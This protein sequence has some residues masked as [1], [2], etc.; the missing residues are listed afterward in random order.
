MA[1]A[2]SSINFSVETE[3]DK[4]ET[5]HIAQTLEQRGL[6]T[7]LTCALEC[8][9]A[10]GTYNGANACAERVREKLDAAK[11]TSRKKQRTFAFAGVLAVA[12][13]FA[14]L[15]C[16]TQLVI[17]GLE[18]QQ[19]QNELA[20]SYAAAEQLE[21]D[22]EYSAAMRA[23]DDLGSYSDAASRADA[24]RLEHSWDDVRVGDYVWLG[25]YEQDN[26]TTNGTEAVEWRVLAVEDG[27]A[28]IVSLYGLEA[29]RFYTDPTAADANNWEQ[30]ELKAWMET[31]FM[32][33]LFSSDEQQR[34]AS[35]PF[36]LSAD[37]ADEYFSSDTD[38]RCKGTVYLEHKENYKNNSRCYWRLRTAGAQSYYT[39][40]VLPSGQID[41]HARV[42]YTAYAIRPAVWVNL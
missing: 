15:F 5:F 16:A 12:F 35:A 11:N 23:F 41:P 30:S 1:D 22:G 34:L 9:E 28:L 31:T 32:Q 18:Q 38:R 13:I 2:N 10:L 40:F 39:D 29:H 7:S 19:Q 20:A 37:E 3:A 6:V 25:A 36:C 24:I 21:A 42:D 27:K 8:Y 33:A 17:P 26:D 14:A 4:A